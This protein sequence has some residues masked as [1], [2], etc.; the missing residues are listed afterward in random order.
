M[1][2]YIGLIIKRA[3]KE[4]GL[5]QKK[6]I[7]KIGAHKVSVRTLRRIEHGST[8]VNKNLTKEL[9]RFFRLKLNYTL[10]DEYEE[11][12][13]RQ[14]LYDEYD[15]MKIQ[16]RLNEANA[17][18][19]EYRTLFHHGKNRFKKFPIT[20]LAEFI[21][22][23]PL[24]DPECLNQAV[25]RIGGKCAGRFY[26]LLEQMDWVYR[27]I[28]DSK[29]KQTADELVNDIWDDEDTIYDK[30]INKTMADDYKEYEKLLDKKFLSAK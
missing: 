22:Y 15:D 30:Y 11:K 2:K 7:E 28:P 21:I 14:W 3:R 5:S 20:S 17:E 13:M 29:L 27:S 16:D 8:T 23:Y 12:I 4:R 6:L 10:Q 25:W 26:Y 1:Q 9:L 19:E 24:M 18:I